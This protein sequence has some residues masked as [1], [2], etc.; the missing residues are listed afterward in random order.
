MPSSSRLPDPAII[1]ELRKRV[2]HADENPVVPGAVNGDQNPI[3][4][5]HSEMAPLLRSEPFSDRAAW[6]YLHTEFQRQQGTIS[7]QYPGVW[8]R[9][10]V[11]AAKGE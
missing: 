11:N 3:T 9:A 10:V 7:G 8:I 1:A 4:V 5:W 2:E 6:G